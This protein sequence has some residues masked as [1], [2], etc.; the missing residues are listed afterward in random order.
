MLRIH[1]CLAAELNETEL[2]FIQNFDSFISYVKSNFFAEYVQLFAYP[3]LKGDILNC[4]TSYSGQINIIDIKVPYAQNMQIFKEAQAKLKTIADRIEKEHTNLPFDKSK[5]TE[6]LRSE[7]LTYTIDSKNPVVIPVIINKALKPAPVVTA[8]AAS[9][10]MIRNLLVS[11]LVLVLTALL[12]LFLFER[13]QATPLSQTEH[14]ADT[15]VEDPVEE[16]PLETESESIEESVKPDDKIEEKEPEKICTTVINEDP[17]EIAIV[18]DGS[19]SMRYQ[20]GNS[21]RIEMAKKAAMDLVNSS[22][23]KTQFSLVM[24]NQCD[25][26][27]NKGSFTGNKKGLTDY[28]ASINPLEGTPLVDGILKMADLVDGIDQESVA[29]VISDGEDSCYKT[30]DVDLCQLGD[31]I[32]RAK[33]K[34]KINTVFIGDNLEYTDI[35]CLSRMTKGRSYNPKDGLSLAE[36]LKKAAS[37]ETEVCK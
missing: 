31:E 30:M 14:D 37:Y 5:I 22:S 32:H 4:L 17:S 9:G 36:D 3:E 7:L 1:R 28:I 11:L 12:I 24:V 27:L 26:A 35:E 13:C 18:F 8:P 23:E 34:L 6:L 21:T 25:L 16:V 29:V 10:H 2:Y 33:P 20:Y 19:G 15:L